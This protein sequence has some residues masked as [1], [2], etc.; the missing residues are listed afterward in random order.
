MLAHLNIDLHDTG[1]MALLCHLIKN[2]KA[3]LILTKVF[4]R[5]TRYD[6]PGRSGQKIF[7]FDKDWPNPGVMQQDQIYQVMIP[8]AQDS[9]FNRAESTNGIPDL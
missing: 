8:T 9:F 6:K 4:K 3:S 2:G 7:F 5:L 1:I